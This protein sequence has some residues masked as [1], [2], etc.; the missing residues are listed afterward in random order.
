MGKSKFKIETI[1]Q[2]IMN[3]LFVGKFIKRGLDAD[4]KHIIEKILNINKEVNYENY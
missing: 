2:I 3:V 1:R 4:S